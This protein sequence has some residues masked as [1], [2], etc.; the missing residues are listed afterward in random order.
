MVL[1]VELGRAARA[2]TSACSAPL[3]TSAGAMWDLGTSTIAHYFDALVHSKAREQLQSV[4]GITQDTQEAVARGPGYALVLLG[5]GLARAGGRQPVPVPAAGRRACRLVAG[6]D[7]CAAGA[8]RCA[9][10]RFSSVGI[11][12]LAFLV[13]NGISN[14]ISRLG[15]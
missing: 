5:A 7:A 6:R 9:M 8:C 14:D 2:R 3:G 15:G 4:V 13:L 12:L 10:W 11:V 1:G